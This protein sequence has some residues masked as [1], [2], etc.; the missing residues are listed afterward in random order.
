MGAPAKSAEEFLRAG[1][2]AEALESL[3]E[4]IRSDPSDAGKRIFLFQLN[5]VMGE[6]DKA[7]NQL[8][9][10]ADLDKD[11]QLMARVGRAALQCEV[12]RRG[13]FEGKRS[14][15]LLG[16]PEQWVGL[17]LQAAQ[18]SGQ[19]KHDQAAQLRAE[20]FEAAEAVSG[21]I[22]VA[23]GEEMRGERFEW[24]ADA[25]ERLG[26]MVE[27]IVEGKYYWIPF[28]HIRAIYIEPPADLRDMV[29]APVTFRWTNGGEAV[30]LMP[31]RYPGS[32]RSQ[33]SAIL[34]ARKTDFESVGDEV[35]VGRGQRMWATDAGEYP[36]LQTRRIELDHPDAPESQLNG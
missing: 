20:G 11:V 14:P 21:T 5:C 15:L 2:I 9:V 30:G 32:E 33:D 26:P 35:Y 13:V 28:S 19:G 10:A 8:N 16:E 12:F 36:L 6:W 18:L 29:W 7:L 24:I 25:D 3:R 27:A 22:S 31:T 23:D 34:L 1:R 17:M 4:S